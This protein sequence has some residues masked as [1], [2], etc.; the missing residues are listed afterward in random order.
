MA[1]PLAADMAEAALLE[2]ASTTEVE[3]GDAPEPMPVPSVDVP[4]VG[5]AV[6]NVPMELD[7]AAGHRSV[8]EACAEVTRNERQGPV[9]NGQ[10]TVVQDAEIERTITRGTAGE[11]VEASNEVVGSQP[12]EKAAQPFSFE[13][14]YNR[15]VGMF[16][17]GC[18]GSVDHGGEFVI[19]DPTVNVWVCLVVKA[20]V[21]ACY[22]NHAGDICRSPERPD[23]RLSKEEGQGY[24]VGSL[25]IGELLAAEARAIGK[26]VDYVVSV[27][28]KAKQ[29]AKKQAKEKRRTARAT[30]DEEARAAALASVEEGEAALLAERL[31]E[32]VAAT[33]KLPARTT[34]VVES[35][36][37]P[38]TA[39]AA[40]AKAA[41]KLGQLR[42]AAA[43]AEAAVLPAEAHHTAA[44]RRVE[45]VQQARENLAML[46]FHHALAGA[47]VPLPE[48]GQPDEAYEAHN[49][50]HDELVA[51]REALDARLSQLRAE[52][53]CADE[54]AADARDAAELARRAA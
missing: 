34:V 24:L 23:L 7:D 19:D 10:R 13:I 50:K 21:K 37:K 1:V 32:S 28:E 51:E 4:S 40:A 36:P 6:E 42:A 33:L 38:V 54:A 47:E 11:R 30:E 29:E 22:E 49:Q 12:S 52:R 3:L 9:T 16:A 45:R 41:D 53:N 31:R 20:A 18:D 2:H 46:I 17:R 5:T 39:A 8:E 15:A 43:R 14:A 26:R 44:K 48:S 35:K 27:E 25:V